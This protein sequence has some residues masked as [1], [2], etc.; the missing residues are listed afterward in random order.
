MSYKKP[1]LDSKHY[2]DLFNALPSLEGKTIGITGTTSGTGFVAA[3]ACG[4]L[5][6]NVILLNR[7]SERSKKA[8]W[9]LIQETPNANF[10]QIECDLQSFDSVRK[11]AEEIT[12]VCSDGLDVICNNAGVMALEDLPTEDGFDVQIQTNHLSHFLLVKLVF[13]LLKKAASL[14]EEAR[15]VNHS[16]IARKQPKKVLESKYLE[17][18]G[19]NLG[20][21]GSSIFFG[22][23]RW[24][25]YNQSK[26]ANAAFTACLHEKLQAV[27][28]KIKA[29]VAHPGLAETDLQSTTV[30]QG[31]MGR[32]IT[33]QMMKV[34][35]S[36]EDGALGILR[37]IADPEIMSGQ[38]V[39]PGM[40][41]MFTAM[42]G[43]AE[44]FP[45]EEFYDNRFTKD[46]LWKKSC[47]AIKEDF[48][49]S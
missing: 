26:L 20:G 5:G 47:E 36:R 21:N 43:R 19:G 31:G 17:K 46:L 11:A 2:E 38:F 10:I 27:D 13:P 14:R 22:G 35:Q 9:E 40:G 28:S 32:W 39:G 24:L 30:K 48:E 41:G 18:N 23:A 12:E 1:K 34:G 49:I 7:S 3:S 42:K 45:L 29:M 37:C 6:A 15:I 44:S 25:R 16:S 4:K 8:Y 33:E